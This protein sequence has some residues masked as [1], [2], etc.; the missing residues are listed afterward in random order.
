MHSLVSEQVELG[1]GKVTSCFSGG[2]TEP[3]TLI[4]LVDNP[5]LQERKET[6][7]VS[8]ITSVGSIAYR[9]D[10]GAEGTCLYA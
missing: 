8:I 4:C 6:A 2:L 9:M 10:L 1:P 5:V 3:K 7:A